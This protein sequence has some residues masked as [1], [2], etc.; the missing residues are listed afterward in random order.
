M[1]LLRLLQLQGQYPN[2]LNT[3]TGPGYGMINLINNGPNTLIISGAFPIANL[4]KLDGLTNLINYCRP[5]FPPLGE[6]QHSTHT[7]RYSDAHQ[8]CPGG[9]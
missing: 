2:L 6:W 7:G 5:I 3:V 4:R 9:L 8:L 1:F